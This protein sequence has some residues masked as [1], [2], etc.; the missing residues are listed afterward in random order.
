MPYTVFVS[1]GSEDR[2]I[3]KQMA[4]N[5]KNEARAEFFIDFLNI[6][7]GERI[8]DK[9]HSGLTRCTELVSFLTPYSVGRN[10]VWSEL[11]AAYGL[12]KPYVAVLYG[13]TRQKIEK[14]YGGLAI[15]ESTKLIDLNDF[16]AYLN[17]LK[18]RVNLVKDA[19]G[20]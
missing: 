6:Q 17:E 15:L 2:W 7:S 10:W 12:K 3:A 5:I 18:D 20:A 9:V 4:L 14:K 8:P 1:Y 16:D 11:G 13:L 19:A